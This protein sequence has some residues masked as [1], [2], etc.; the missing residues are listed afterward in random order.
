MSALTVQLD[1]NGQATITTSD[2]DNN[3]TDNCS[4]ASL[5]I[6]VT[7]FDCTNL[8]SNTVVLTVTDGSG[9]T[10]TCSTNVTVVDNI[11]PTA[12]C[13]SAL[14]VQLD[15]NGQATITTSDI[16]NNSTDNCSI[17]SLA[18]NVTSFCLLYTSP[19]PRD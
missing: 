14:T 8:G 18:I 15:G 12:N 16:D 10:S 5:A 4:I 7:S 3:S 13:V 17:A 2:I 19:S 6:N 1:G 9:N 11:A